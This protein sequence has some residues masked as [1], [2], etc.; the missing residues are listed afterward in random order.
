MDSLAIETRALVKR[1]GDVTALDGVDLEVPRGARFGLLGPNGAGKTTAVSILATLARPTSGCARLLGRDVVS[2][3]RRVRRDIGLVFQECTLDLELTAREQLDL[4]ARLYHL[5]GRRR[6]VDEVL[7][8]VG[9]EGDA[10]R[11]AR[12]LSGGMRRRL[13]I[14]RGLL[15]HPRVLFLD[16][17][18]LGLDVAAR[19]D[20]WRHLRGLRDAGETTLF[21]TTHSMEEADSLCERLAIL[22]RGRI[23][24]QGSPSELK[25]ELG[26]D[27][28][29]LALERSAAAAASL[30]GVEGVARV[31][32]GRPATADGRA[33]TL[34][35]TVAEGS[36]RLPDLLDAARPYG[37][38]E[39]TLHRPTLE[40][41]FLH[42]TGHGFEP[43][44]D[45]IETGA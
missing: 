9:L 2:E 25:A 39:V 26:G 31:V 43:A 5:D 38:V 8:L 33:G 22:D 44:A 42:H 35:I 41:V 23:V 28:V 10:D 13:E 45:E 36:R 19:A 21:L 32:P 6:R 40:H 7:A 12:G 16:E 27:I 1:F 15:H 20:I 34:R 29:I 4:H 14:A 17:P 30:R 18:T 11:L 24:A 37:V 3:R